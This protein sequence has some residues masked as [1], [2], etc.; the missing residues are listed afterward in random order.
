MMTNEKKSQRHGKLVGLSELPHAFREADLSARTDQFHSIDRFQVFGERRSGT[1]A[2]EQFFSRNTQLKPTRDY[3]WK[4]GFPYFP[5]LPQRCLFV[6]VV[7]DPMA[8]LRSFYSA[9]FEAHPDL[10]ALSFP[11]FLRAEWRGVFTPRRSGWRGHGYTLDMRVGQREELQADRHPISGRRFQN[12]VALRNAKLTGH[13]SL[14]DRDINACLLRYE[15]FLKDRAAVL[16]R[17]CQRFDIERQAEYVPL[18][19]P[20]GPS[21]RKDRPKGAISF[22]PEDTAFVLDQLDIAQECKC[23]YRDVIKAA[24]AQIS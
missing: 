22:R 13:L 18:A 10:A 15:D 14:L 2:V 8:W 20:V 3:G 5:V 11:D 21:S 12:V 7:R 23:G 19:D 6:V 9:P 1:N 17:I 4:H 24:Y 16:E